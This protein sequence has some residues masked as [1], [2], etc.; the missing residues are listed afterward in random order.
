MISS[1]NGSVVYLAPQ[2][3]APLS[4]STQAIALALAVRPDLVQQ[5]QK[6]APPAPGAFRTPPAVPAVVSVDGHVDV[7]A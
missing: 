2:V 1:V 5:A 7:Y 6:D 3:I 4:P